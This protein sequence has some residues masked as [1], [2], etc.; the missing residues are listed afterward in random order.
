MRHTVCAQDT[1]LRERE[2]EREGERELL[3][4]EMMISVVVL[5]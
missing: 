5:V 2:R 1:K 3:L 4:G